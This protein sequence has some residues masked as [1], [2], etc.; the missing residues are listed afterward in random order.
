MHVLTQ[1]Q[2]ARYGDG[3][4]CTRRPTGAVTSSVVPAGTVLWSSPVLVGMECVQNCPS[5]PR[6]VGTKGGERGW[7]ASIRPYVCMC[8]CMCV[9]IY[10]YRNLKKSLFARLS[11]NPSNKLAFKT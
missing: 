11:Q 5:V 6:S 1:L 7:E 4:P 10:I 9:S 3:Q 2:N 8:V